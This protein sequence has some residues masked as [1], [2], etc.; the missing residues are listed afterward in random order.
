MLLL[1]GEAGIGKSRLVAEARARRQEQVLWLEG[2]CL[3]MTAAASYGPFLDALRD[4]FGW[5]LDAEEAAQAA[6]MREGLAR[7]AAALRVGRRDV[8]RDRC[9]AR[10]A[11][12]GALWRTAC[13]QLG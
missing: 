9:G 10:Q 11:V 1:S 8:R 3:E 5:Q 2:R 13:P 7:L 6:A 12:C 4:Y